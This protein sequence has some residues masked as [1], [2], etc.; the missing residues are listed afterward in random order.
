MLRTLLDHSSTA[1]RS[2]R[3]ALAI[4][5]LG[6]VMFTSQGRLATAQN[7]SG[8]T[9]TTDVAGIAGIALRLTAVA[10]SGNLELQSRRRAVDAARALERATGHAPAA[11]VALSL[12][13]G[14]GLDPAGGNAE[15]AV[16]RELFLGARLAAARGRA[17]VELAA[18]EQELAARERLLSSQ[19][20]SLLANAASQLR[21]ERRLTR[22]DRLLEEAETALRVRFAVGSARYVDVLRVRT[23]RLEARV[24][25]TA[26]RAESMAAAS[27]L[28]QFIGTADGTP[29]LGLLDSAASDALSASWLAA[30]P[31]PQAADT[32]LALHAEVRMARAAVARAV[33]ASRELEVLRRPQL[34]GLA[35]LQ[36]ISP[37]NGGNSAS[38]MFGFSSTLPFTARRSNAL[39]AEASMQAIGASRAEEAAVEASARAELEQNTARY[40]A[41]RE[42]LR[43][44]DEALLVAADAEREAALAA[45]RAGTLT[46]L[47]LLDFEQALVGVEVERARSLAAAADA[48]LARFGALNERNPIP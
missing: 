29:V 25:L 1:R 40:T 28:V 9:D 44:F 10:R 22:R 24:Q 16:S 12:S 37:V 21:L 20:L 23:A 42:R 18:T 4:R 8:S 15:L 26:A 34:A 2:A 17:S 35:G 13:D 30:L 6:L 39:T 45:F 48:N 46:L 11:S 32:A 14:P 43:A 27:A 5:L 31:V 19:V 38:F 36:R 3:R 47:E 33:A 41:A 7:T